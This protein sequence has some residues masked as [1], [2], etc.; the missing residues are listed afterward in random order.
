MRIRIA[1]GF[2]LA[3]LA[4]AQLQAAS[5]VVPGIFLIRGGFTPG[6][7]PDGNSV[8]LTAPDGL[9]VVD[10]GRHVEHTQAIVDFARA[11][12][13]PVRAIVNTHWHLDHIGGNALLRREFPD[14]HIYASGALANAR[15]GFLSRYR[16]QLEDM[17]K[18]TPDENARKP[19]QSELA[20][21]DSA[22]ALAPDVVIASSGKQ[23][24]AGRA[25][26]VSLEQRAVTEGDV[27]IYDK[28]SGVLIAGDLVTLPAP[29]LDTACPRRWK[30]S[31][32]RLARTDFELLIPGHGAPLTRR[33]FLAYQRA[34]D[35]LLTCAA[36]AAAKSTCIEGWSADIA[37]L[38]GDAD[39]KFVAA[40]MD[41]YVD[42]LKS[43]DVNQYCE[44]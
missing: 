11:A 23:T 9:I 44:P 6:A 26:D 39:P 43:S 4:A 3:L 32:D 13:L 30:E 25:L 18:N 15:K 19:F 36:G 31:L 10:T 38:T 35:H 17:I 22:A 27:W 14:L 20:I 7:Q 28:A 41:Y 8:I 5:E 42:A 12:K 40:L 2:A 21:I 37:G 24:I 1:V 33:Q 29:F 16:A 34:F